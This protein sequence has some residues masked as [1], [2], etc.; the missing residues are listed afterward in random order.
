MSA[1][2]VSEVTMT[3]VVNAIATDDERTNAIGFNE[4]AKSLAR[5]MLA[6]ETWAAVPLIDAIKEAA[7]GKSDPH[8]GLTR[9][10]RELYRMNQAAII[11]R[12]GNRPNDEY[13][14]IPDYKYDPAHLA[15]EGDGWRVVSDDSP[16]VGA[17]SEL[18]YQCSEGDVPTWALFKRL[19]E[20][21]DRIAA[22][23]AKGAA[24]RAKAKAASDAERRAAER[25]VHGESNRHLLTKDDRPNW[26]GYRLAAE[27]I[28]RE[29][30]RRFPGVKFTVRSESYSMG[31]SVNVSWTDG[32]TQKAVEEVTDR[33]K[34]GSF[35]G[36]T[37]SYTT[38]RDNTFGDVFGTAKYV[39]AQREWTLTAVRAA[40]AKVLGW[41]VSEQWYN[42]NDHSRVWHMRKAWA[43]MS[44]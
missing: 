14:A 3:K 33:H 19:A 29:L 23:W 27:N 5:A 20:A 25:R 13:Q 37:D 40:V 44:F 41:E 17:I 16:E 32:P 21:N 8:A 6:D 36:M 26:S 12:Y 24:D 15:Q 10:G 22:E 18:L 34:G 30:K 38:D 2:I 28:R 43:E 39:F 4:T 9:L 42:D 1:Y 31:N 35:D 7:T 11:A